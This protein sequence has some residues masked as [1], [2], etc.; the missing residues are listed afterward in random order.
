MFPPIVTPGV[1]TRVCVAPATAEL[2]PKGMMIIQGSGHRPTETPLPST[3]NTMRKRGK[4][5]NLS[6]RQMLLK[7]K[8]V[9]DKQFNVRKRN[10]L[11]HAINKKGPQQMN[12]GVAGLATRHGNGPFCLFVFFFNSMC[13][14][15]YLSPVKTC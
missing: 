12:V 10:D 7:Q 9:K 14:G 6:R 2:S 3:S 13:N 4:L 15:L 5:A 8:E 11:N 1:G